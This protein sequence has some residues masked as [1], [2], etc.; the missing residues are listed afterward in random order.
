[1]DGIAPLGGSD[2][3][4]LG[5][6]RLHGV[7]GGGG[8]G[9]VYLGRGSARR[10][11]RKQTVAVRGLRPELLRDRQQ[12][13][14]LRQETQT[15]A[16]GVRS[17]YVAAPL[18]CEP[19]SERP[20]LAA[21]FVPGPSLAALVSRYGPMQ[22]EAV[23]ALGGAL[24]RALVALHGAGVVHGDLRARNVLLAADAPRAV[25]HGLGPDRAGGGNAA[26]KAIA[27]A[28]DVFALGAVLVFA[29][30]AHPPF[31]GGP[32]SARYDWADLR[33][34]P[35]GLHPALL[36]CLHHDAVHRP[37]PAALARVLDLGDSAELPARDWLPE[38]YVHEIGLFEQA[39]RRM[40]GRRLFGR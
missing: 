35:E 23:R 4:R 9:T 31:R 12:R 26:E 16:T 27:M 13:A 15:L 30:T 7:L 37:Q 38:P 22:E 36:A 40:T 28:D 20:W 21:E 33:G 25:D 18:D 8:T 14:R 2:P 39:A 5:P 6:F 29:A 32:Q 1:M 3:R 34:V 24:C 17:P 11:G 10:G 19:D